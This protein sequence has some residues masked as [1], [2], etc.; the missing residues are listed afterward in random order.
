MACLF[1]CMLA[2]PVSANPA[3]ATIT[4]DGPDGYGITQWP[5]YKAIDITFSR[6][7]LELPLYSYL[8]ARFTDQMNINGIPLSDRIAQASYLNI[9]GDRSGLYGN[10][11][12]FSVLAK[13]KFRIYYAG[14][15]LGDLL[16]GQRNTLTLLA[17]FPVAGGTLGE[18][19]TLAL[20]P[21]TDNWEQLADI[22]FTVNDPLSTGV[23]K[24]EQYSYKVID[25]HCS[26]PVTTRSYGQQLD[27]ALINKITINGVALSDRIAKLP[28]LNIGDCTDLYGQSASVVVLSSS[29]FRIYYCGGGVGDLELEGYNTIVLEEGFLAENVALPSPV[30]LVMNP[31]ANTWS[32][33]P[34]LRVSVSDPNGT[35]VS[36]WAGYDYK[37]IDITCSWPVF[38]GGYGS[39]LSTAFTTKIRINGVLLSDRIAKLAS[40]NIGDCSDLYNQAASANVLSTTTF[41]LYYCGGGQGDL[42]ADQRNTVEFLSGFPL[43]TV[44]ASSDLHAAMD[45]VTLRWS[46]HMPVEPAEMADD[47]QNHAAAENSNYTIPSTVALLDGS[48]GWEQNEV[49]VLNGFYSLYQPEIIY[50]P[51]EEYPYRMYFMGWA[52]NT[53]NDYQVLPDSSIYQGYPG[54]DAIFFARSKNMND[55]QVYS[56]TSNG[57]GSVYWDTTSHVAD[58]VPV[59]TCGTADYDNY[60]VGDPSIVYQN[61]IYYMAYSAM[62]LDTYNPNESNPY[63]DSASCIMGA[64]SVDGLHWTKSASP[65]LIWENEIG[66]DENVT[67][68]PP[69]D[70]FYGMY[71][72]PSLLFEDGVWKLWYDYWAGYGTGNGTS[73]GYAENDGD[74]L[75]GFTRINGNT[76]PLINNFVDI[77]VVKIGSIYY[78]YGDPFLY[79]HGIYDQAI[80]NDSPEW[81][82]RQIVELQSYDG[83]NWTVTGYFRPDSDAPTNQIPQVFINQETEQVCIFYATQAGMSGGSY[84]WH[85]KNF[86]YLYRSLESFS[87][88]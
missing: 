67:R 50:I 7:F 37:A 80:A 60:H 2:L 48:E 69:V 40:L 41:R 26:R 5:Y 42:L 24:W 29:S 52:L 55:W 68:F 23:S 58:W 16:P 46:D 21:A 66:N 43:F 51:G 72:R 36:S 33:L 73:I 15:G 78:T 9:T 10:A 22:S 63:E 18:E 59:I 8:P 53:C 74:F 17:G 3:P 76:T 65:I 30:W 57:T 61:G 1:L 49:D 79:A 34:A 87:T 4:V 31:S 19:V 35:G 84:D 81:S 25:V 77:D 45:T 39:S 44:T 56:K 88:D 12:S 28:A 14:G 82:L 62:G 11:I 20:N 32:T 64:V 85:W 86:R 83:Y 6:D 47:E 38:T 75:D 13:N 70:T 54:G 71:Q 27:T